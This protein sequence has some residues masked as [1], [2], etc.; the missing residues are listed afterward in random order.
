MFTKLS[1]QDIT[2]D[3]LTLVQDVF[4]AGDLASDVINVMPLDLRP[5]MTAIA[6]AVQAG[7]QTAAQIALAELSAV[8]EG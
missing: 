4:E 2:L 3:V 7:D 5:P 6:A 8:L 1:Q